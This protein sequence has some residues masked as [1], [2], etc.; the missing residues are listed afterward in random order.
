MRRTFDSTR[1]TE[2]ELQRERRKSRASS[3]PHNVGG[4]SESVA[5]KHDAAVVHVGDEE[6]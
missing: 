2:S 4:P 3:Q 1:F 5:R 6:S